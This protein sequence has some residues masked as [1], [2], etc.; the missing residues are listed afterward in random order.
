MA[1]DT[2]DSALEIFAATGPEFGGGLSNHGPMA[3]EALVSL[4]RGEAVEEWSAWYARKLTEPPQ[5][6]YAIDAASWREALGDIGRTGDW[7]A[8][9]RRELGERPWREAVIAWLPRLAPGIM[10][11]ATHGILRTAHAVRSIERGETP[12]RRT[13][14]ADGLAY[15]AAR[16][17]TLPTAPGAGGVL[18]VPDALRLVPRVP[19]GGARGGLI[20][21]R[22]RAVADTDFAAAV[23]HVSLDAALDRFI[24]DVTR[25]FVR[26]YLA[27]AGFAAIAFVHTVT[28]PSALRILA[29]YVAAS[30]AHDVKRYLWQACAAVYAVYGR[31]APPEGDPPAGAVDAD[32]LID[33]A[34]RA[35]DEHAI[36]FTEACLR[37]QRLTGDDTFLAAA[38]DAVSRLRS[39]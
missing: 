37:E 39:G 35:R 7:A 38:S 6:R 5:S 32:D 31:N 17:Q 36:K 3:A 23:N 28:A 34:V 33:R 22:V 13:E 1:N 8:F 24:S 29:P 19:D 11:G 10:A 30:H 16:Y 2:I 14:L 4:G 21:E 26:W 20:F 25:T 18:D 12:A 27:N 15:W 9:F